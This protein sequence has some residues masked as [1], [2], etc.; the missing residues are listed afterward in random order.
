MTKNPGFSADL[1]NQI[2]QNKIYQ[3]AYMTIDGARFEKVD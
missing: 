1:R 3:F 2:D